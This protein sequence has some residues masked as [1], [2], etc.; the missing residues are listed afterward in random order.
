MVAD[1]LTIGEVSR[2]AGVHVET[3]RYYQTLGIV[4]QPDRP[5]GGFRR[6]GPDDIARLY[7]IK[8]AQQL[9]FALE[10]VKALLQ[11]EDGQNCRETRL[12]AEKKLAIIEQRLADLAG[13]RRVLRRLIAECESGKRPRC[14][15]IIASLARGG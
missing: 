3:I 14:C 7:F 2:A 12:L 6:Y 4:R 10:E 13:M 9:G 5:A 11:L 8:R 15:P 1:T